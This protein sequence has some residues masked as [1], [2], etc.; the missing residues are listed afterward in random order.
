MRLLLRTLV[1]LLGFFLRPFR[2]RWK[3]GMPIECLML[4]YGG[5][6]STGAE[7]RTAEAIRQILATDPRLCV[8]LASLNR[9]QT[10]RYLS[11][12]ERLTVVQF[13]PV[14]VFDLPRL[15][16]RSDLLILVEGS[17]FKENFSPV[18]LWFFLFATDIAQRLSLPTVAYG[19]DAGE[20][21][22]ASRQWTMDVASRMDLIMVR[23]EAAARLLASTGIRQKIHVTT[24]TAFSITA[25][26]D[27]WAKEELQR[28]G[29][30]PKRPIIGIAFREFFW[31]PVLPNLWR[32]MR[33]VTED[34][35]KSIYYHSWGASGK[36]QSRKMMEKVAA[37][38]DWEAGAFNAQIALFAMEHIDVGPCRALASRMQTPAVLFDADHLDAKQMTAILR[39]LEL[40]VTCSYHAFILSMAGAVPTVGLAHDERIASLMD[41]LGFIHDAFISHE[42]ER[43]FELL[44]EKSSIVRRDARRFRQ[45]LEKAM[46]DY[47]RRMA[48]N[49]RLFGELIAQKFP[50]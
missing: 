39:Q 30:D 35:Y 42:E 10:L 21:S 46:P 16:L 25:A 19:V 7:A 41:E 17:C 3:K 37:Y 47:L 6:N 50:I 18:L 26:S 22:R 45:A 20:L 28:S 11:E 48:E 23:T 9:R 8:I 15:L 1:V 40:L 14:F 44:K 32:T 2:R 33:G 43:I 27:Q 34:R 5:A 38:A 13:H 12:S 31:W 49:G 29:L 24:D 4:G 36:A